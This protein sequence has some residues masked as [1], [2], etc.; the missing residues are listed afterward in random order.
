MA[1]FLASEAVFFVLLILAFIYYH[2]NLFNQS[3]GSPPNAGRVL[4]PA[5]TGI[6]TVCLLASS[7]TIWWA[8]QSLKRGNQTMVRLGSSRPS[9]SA[10]SSSSGRG[11]EYAHL[12]GENVTVSRNLFGSTFFT[13]TGFHGFHVFMGLVAITILF[14]LAIGGLVQGAALRRAGGGLALLA[15]RRCRLDRH[16]HDDLPLGARMTT[17]QLLATAWDWEPSVLARLHRADR[18]LRRGDAPPPDRQAWSFFAGVV[19]LLFAQCSP[20]DALGDTYLFSAHM[21]QH[22]LLLLIVPP[23]LILGIPAW[24]AEQWLAV[25]PHRAGWSA[26]SVNRRSRGYS[27]S[28]RCTSGISPRSTTRRSRMSASISSSI[29]ASS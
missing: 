18:R 7:V 19:V 3:S 24:L 11:S 26:R 28:A 2:K 20:L 14:G 5:K 1:L 27:A 25:A 15:L 23:L 8:G 9:C 13:L 4:D 6:Y 17:A 22:L 29:S 10:R 12:I 21:I 16:L